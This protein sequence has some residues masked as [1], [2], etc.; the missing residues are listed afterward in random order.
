MSARRD[1]Q[2]SGGVGNAV[3]LDHDE[4]E[5]RV[6]SAWFCCRLDRKE[7]K[8]LSARRDGPALRHLGLWAILWSAAGRPRTC[9]SPRRGA[10]LPFLP[11]ASS[12]R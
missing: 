3:G 10:F 5:T 12:T 8:R 1:Y 11:T 9:C 6:E 7:L 2:L 4:I